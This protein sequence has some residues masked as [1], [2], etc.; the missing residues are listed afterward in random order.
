MVESMPGDEFAQFEKAPG[1]VPC[2][3][4]LDGQTANPG[5][6]MFPPPRGVACL[7]LEISITPRFS[8]WLSN[9]GFR[10][11]SPKG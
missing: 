10:D 4:C 8:G 7:L 3:P 11:A 5:I 6:G 2:R 9:W 1:R